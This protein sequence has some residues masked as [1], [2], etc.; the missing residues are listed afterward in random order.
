MRVNK[1]QSDGLCQLRCPDCYEKYIGQSDRP[2]ATRVKENVL[3]S[4]NCSNSKFYQ[5]LLHDEHAIMIFD[6]IRIVLRIT[7][8]NNIN[9]AHCYKMN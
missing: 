8:V 3:S 4:Q 1:P 5:H 6:K 9:S 7:K 2:F